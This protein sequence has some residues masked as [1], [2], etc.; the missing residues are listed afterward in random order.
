[1]KKVIFY[2]L[3][4]CLLGYF[5]ISAQSTT[6]QNLSYAI[7]STENIQEEVFIARN[8]VSQLVKELVILNSPNIP[9]FENRM[10]NHV[11]SVLNNSDDV[12]YFIG[13]AHN[14]SSVT[15]DSSSVILD[16]NELVNQNDIIMYYVSETVTAINANNTSIALNHLQAISTVLTT[17]NSIAQNMI[18]NIEIIQSNTMSFNVCIKLVDYQGNPTTYNA[19]FYALNTATNEAFYPGRPEDQDYGYGNCFYN[20]A[21]GNYNFDSYQDYFCGTSSENVTLSQSL[22]NSNGVIEVTL[23]VWCE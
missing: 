11:N 4:I 22:V 6:E 10:T 13:L 16:A 8:A 20:L 23:R 5:P 12:Q 17:Q 9:L 1:M 19:G 18:S 14:S 7:Q 21:P 3:M 2:S 15:F